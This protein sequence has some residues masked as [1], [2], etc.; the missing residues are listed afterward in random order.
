LASGNRTFFKE[1]GSAVGSAAAHNP[2][3][4]SG[5]EGAGRASKHQRLGKVEGLRG[6]CRW[7]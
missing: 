3:S 5:Y 4:N 2:R 7:T 6:Q 1:G